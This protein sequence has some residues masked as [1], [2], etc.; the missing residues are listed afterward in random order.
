MTLKEGRSVIVLDTRDEDIF[1]VWAE[2]VRD[3][4][5]GSFVNLPLYLDGLKGVLALYAEA[6]LHFTDR[7]VRL[8]EEIARDLSLGYL[9]IVKTR[10]LEKALF[11]DLLTG[12][13]NQR[14]LLAALE[15][16]IEV[17]RIEKL[18]LALVKLDLDH[19]SSLNME[20]GRLKGDRILKVVGERLSRL[21]NQAGTL[22]RIGSDEFAFSYLL[23]RISPAL[24]LTHLENLFQEPIRVEQEEVKVSASVGI[25][26]FPEDAS[27]PEDL[28]EA[29][30]VALREAKTRA[31]HGVAFFS[32]NLSKKAFRHF[33]LIREL[34]K[35]LGE[36][37]FELFFQPRIR[38]RERRPASLEALLRWRHPER[39]LVMSGEFIPVLEESGLIVEVGCWVI[40]EAACFLRACRESFP[41]MRIS[42][43]VSVKQF[44]A[45]D[46]LIRVLQEILEDGFL[47][48]GALEVE[49]TESLLLE[50]GPE[51]KSLLSRI[52]ELGIE[53]ALDDFGTGYS[54]FAYLKE[55]PAH[56]LKVDYSFVR[57]LPESREDAEA[58]MAIVSMARNL[59]KR[60]VAEGVERREQLAFLAGL[61]VDEVQGF[62]FSRPLVAEETL[63]FLNNFRSERFFW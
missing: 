5:F 24:L 13:P 3:F 33:A 20:L 56:T 45:R 12:L 30:S 42:F 21:V 17:A 27:S 52:H 49:I 41:K 43:N 34:K 14:F 1:A 29:A 60:V 36:Q 51:A 26:L 62:L 23:Q 55:I 47:P 4:G 32:P 38:L 58:V 31:P 15:H 59:G 63:K 8:L 35:A 9:H 40:L 6:P 37:Q 44:M 61:G 10:E 11:R 53:I 18:S 16:E 19:F 57:G 48:P 46:R 2:K 28:M 7:E 54:S 39:G 25:A 50:A 22:A